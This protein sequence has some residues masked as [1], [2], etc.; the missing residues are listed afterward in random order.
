M[1]RRSQNGFLKVAIIFTIILIAWAWISSKL[2]F[3]SFEDP[4]DI[5][6]GS[7]NISD[8]GTGGRI[9][10]SLYLS[11]GECVSE[12][13]TTTKNGRTTSSSTD[14]Y[15]AIPVDGD[16]PDYYYY[17][18]VVVDSDDKSTL[19][20]ITNNTY[21]YFNDYDLSHLDREY[22]FEG[23]LKEMDDDVY[24]YVKDW[25]KEGGWTSEEIKEYVLPIV[26]TPMNFDMAPAYIIIF[27][28]ILLFTILFWV[29]FFVKK[30]K[31]KA[32]AATAQ[33]QFQAQFPGQEYGQYVVINGVSYPKSSMEH[34]NTYVNNH[35][36]I[37]AIQELRNMTGL[38]L[39]EAKAVIDNWYQYYI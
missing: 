18:C 11:L 28:V 25:F 37:T 24:D 36:T 35:E 6:D 16:D 1:R 8:H 26:L 27:I 15:Y 17:I 3:L 19:N 5:Y 32:Q 38:G 14:Y 22:K 29:L 39:A 4:I 23:T 33:A 31:L 13:T 2:I 12:T 7:F 21:D 34:I 10:S 30:S 9:E 20:A